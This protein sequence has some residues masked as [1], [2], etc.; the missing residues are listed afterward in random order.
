MPVDIAM[1]IILYDSLKIGQE[2]AHQNIANVI[3][4]TTDEILLEGK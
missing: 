1:N 4:S 2:S 3:P